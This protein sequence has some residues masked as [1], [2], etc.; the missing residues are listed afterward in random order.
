MWSVRG[1]TGGCT[2]AFYD[3]VYGGQRKYMTSGVLDA[4]LVEMRLHSAVRMHPS[5]VLMKGQSAS[6]TVCNCEVVGE[7]VTIDR[8]KEI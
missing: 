2:V 4:A 5:F 7:A 6:F 1:C 8:I 3:V